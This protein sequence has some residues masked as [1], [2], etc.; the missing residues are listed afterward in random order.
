MAKAKL[1]MMRHGQSEWNALNLFTGWVDVS[2]SK[3][4]IE[5]ALKGGELIKDF[6]IDVIFMS[7]L[8]RAQ[9]TA[10]LA[11][12]VH[13]SKKVPVVLHPR[14]GKL[15]EWSTIY[16]PQAEKTTVPAHVAWELNE[17]M[18]GQLQGLN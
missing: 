6:P 3:R 1:I 12:S 8:I 16:N 11:M 18:Y 2:L 5:E 7:S 17:R 4:G 13:H 14:E 15:Q 9:M 10:M